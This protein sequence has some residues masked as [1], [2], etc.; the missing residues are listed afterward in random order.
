MNNITCLEVAGGGN[1]RG[2]SRAALRILGIGFGHDRRPAPAVDG[3]IDAASARQRA[4]GRVDDRIDLFQ[5]DVALM[6]F[7]GCRCAFSLLDV[8][9]WDKIA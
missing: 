8:V 6:K 7:D 3:P 1:H 9:G 5:R 2:T 4:I